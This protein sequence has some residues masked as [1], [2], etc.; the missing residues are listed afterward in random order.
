MSD[1]IGTAGGQPPPQ[2]STEAEQPGDDLTA[3]RRAARR[4]I[5]DAKK[6]ADHILGVALVA[7]QR[8]RDALKGTSEQ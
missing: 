8:A 4:I 1:P 7:L 6:E 3:T 5:D 2:H